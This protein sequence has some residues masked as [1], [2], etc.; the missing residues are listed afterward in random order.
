[1]TLTVM[2]GAIMQA[3]TYRDIASFDRNIAVL[4]AHFDMLMERARAE[5]V[6]A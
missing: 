5:K 4:R 6:P 2:E 1:F 3:R